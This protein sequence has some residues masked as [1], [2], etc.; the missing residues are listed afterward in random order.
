[1][2]VGSG[3]NGTISGSTRPDL[4]AAAAAVLLTE[5]PKDAYELGGAPFTL[6][7]LAAEVARQ[8][9][10]PLVYQD[11]PIEAY[12]AGLAEHGVPQAFAE[13]L[14][15]TSFAISRGDWDTDSTD[16]AQLIGRP[17]TPLADT[18][19]TGLAAL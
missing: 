14:A 2:L 5:D 9:G 18:V 11:L 4:A 15:G 16:L 1:M 3:G 6:A 10:R 19:R 13:L 8:S 17:P 7:D 12:A